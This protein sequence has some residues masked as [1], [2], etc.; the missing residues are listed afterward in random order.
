LDQWP[1][2]GIPDKPR[3][4]LISTAR[5]KAV[6]GIRRRARF[7]GAQRDLAAYIEAR[8]NEASLDDDE[9]ED[10]RLRLIFTCCHPGLPPEGRW[11]GDVRP[12]SL[13]RAPVEVRPFW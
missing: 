11:R 7:D 4:W 3:P 9:I 8:V 12:P 5:F 13:C 1:R 10:D 6:D 2:A